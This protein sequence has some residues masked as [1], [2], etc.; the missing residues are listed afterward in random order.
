VH[1]IIV[2]WCTLFAGLTLT[3]RAEFGLL[4]NTALDASY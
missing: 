2:V 3:A 1:P 4:T